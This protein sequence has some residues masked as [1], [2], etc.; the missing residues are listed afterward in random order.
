MST[1]TPDA[2]SAGAPPAAGPM[3][4]GLNGGNG[5]RR[6]RRRRQPRAQRRDGPFA[7]RPGPREREAIVVCVAAIIVYLVLAYFVFV[8]PGVLALGPPPRGASAGGHPRALRG[9]LAAPAGRPPCLPRAPLRRVRARHRP[10]LRRPAARRG[11]MPARRSPA[12]CRSRPAPCSFVLG[13]WLLWVSRKRGGTLWWTLARRAL[14]AGRGAVRRLLGRAAGQ[15]GHHRHRAPERAGQGRRPRASPREGHA[16]HARRSRAERLVRAV[17][18]PRRHRHLPAPVDDRAGAHAGEERLRRAA[19]RPARLRR[20]SG[21]PQRLRLGVDQGHRRRRGVAAPPS[22]RAAA[23]HRRSRPLDGRR[24]DARGR[25]PQP[26]PQGG[27]QRGRR[28]PLASARR[29]CVAAR[30]RSSW[31]CSIRRTWCRR[32]PCGC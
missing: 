18:E 4:A 26:R 12:C 23:A 15:H 10:R 20:Q 8:R 13:L 7:A 19:G 27:G 25:R 14:L 11:C 16:H 29:C 24:A 9:P 5:Q 30:A 31:R 22:G 3:G 1:T 6:Q 32:S 2:T 28:H 17:A 21:R